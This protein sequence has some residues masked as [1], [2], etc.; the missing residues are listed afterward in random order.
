MKTI[1]TEIG[2][3]VFSLPYL[4]AQDEDLFSAEGLEVRLVPKIR[5]ASTSKLEDHRLV[6]SFGERSSFEDRQTSLYRA[7]QWGQIR[8]SCDSR[9]GGQVVSKRAAVVSQA[10]LVRADSPISR[11]QDLAG[12]TVGVNFHHGSHYTAIQMLEGLLSREKIRVV[13]VGGPFERFRALRDGVVDAA[14]L[15]E[16]W[17][18]AGEKLGYKLVSE[19]FYSG[20]EIACPDLDAET[21]AA[22]KRA[23]TRAVQRLNEDPRPYLHHLIAEVPP[24][25]TELSESDFRLERLRYVDPVPYTEEEFER[26]YEWMLG[27][28][29]AEPGARFETLVDN[30]LPV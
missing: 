24:E 10:I 13:H 21:Y 2:S 28:D 16:P 30:R 22:V 4:V 23:I 11:P 20:S 15:M 12:R 8:R 7:C 17:I 27:W 29:L 1:V 25:V 18:T 5:P 9:R 14:N 19:T 6:S 3:R 26:A